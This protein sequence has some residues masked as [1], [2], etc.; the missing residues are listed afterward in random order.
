M[1]TKIVEKLADKTI[2]KEELFKKVKN[3]YDLIPEII[4]G[5]TS[6]KAAV[7]Y[8]CGKVLM[9]ISKENPEKLYPHMDFFINL[10]DSQ[11]RILIWQS[12]AII[13]NLTRIDKNNKFEKIFEKYFSFIDN[14]YMVTVANVVGHSGKIG[15]AKPHLI[16]KITNELLKV[17]K[18]KT[19]PHLTL[20]C[21]KVI[22]EQAIE[23]F[24]MFFEKVENKKEVFSF[25]EKQRN[26]SRKTLKI[27][28]E[29]FLKKWNN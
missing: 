23:S 7:R 5:M 21:K 11:Y 12:I 17:E 20:E 3:N 15:I 19:T 18:I 29:E 16:N 28:A 14:D 1:N 13:A 6:S 4:N 25:V 8:G 24:D 2:S 9:D 27:K 10:L 22:A 26:S